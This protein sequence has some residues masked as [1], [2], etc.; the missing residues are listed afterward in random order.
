M[1][2]VSGERTEVARFKR[3]VKPTR[4]EETHVVTDLSL[5]KVYP[6]PAG[7]DWYVWC[8]EHWG[9]KWDVEAK[10][11][12]DEPGELTYTFDSA[13]AP[14]VDCLVHASKQ[15]PTLRFWLDYEE[16]EAQVFGTVVMQDG[17][18]SEEGQSKN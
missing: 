4:E 6:I 2:V 5:D 15:Y 13:W 16:P 11:Q 17:H 7:K 8:T 3:A 12:R 1:L 14:P 18:V 10:L 9:T